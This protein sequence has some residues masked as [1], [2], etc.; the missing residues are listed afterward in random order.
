V[1]FRV[2]DSGIGMSGEQ[3]A[4]LFQAFSQVDPS[5]TRRYGGTGLGLAIS[6]Q[7]CQKMGGDITVQSEPGS[8][9]AFTVH[10]PA[11]LEEPEAPEDT[12]PGTIPFVMAPAAERPTVLVVDDDRLVRDLLGRFLA[13]EGF[14]ILA[15]GNGREGLRLAREHRLALVTLDDT[16]PDMDGWEVLKALK[17]DPLTASIPVMM[18]TIVDNQAM[19]YAL[20]ASDYLTKPIDWRRLAAALVKHRAPHAAAG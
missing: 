6:R 17:A 16:M 7:L 13:K 20:G 10:L 19:G 2:T 8:G 9:T 4:K 12:G 14:K 18:I 5:S 1:R 15:A 11:G 3:L